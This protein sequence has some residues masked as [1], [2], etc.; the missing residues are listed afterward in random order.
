MAPAPRLYVFDIDGTLVTTKSGDTR[1]HGAADWKWLPGRLEMARS[2]YASGAHI[3]IATNQSSIA[4]AEITPQIQRVADAIGPAVFVQ[5]AY[6]RG[7][8]DPLRKPAPGMLIAAMRRFGVTPA[9]TVM[10][11]DRPEDH[12]AAMNAGCRFVAADAFFRGRAA[13]E[14]EVA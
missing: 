8:A 9:E 11:G 12:G 1:R 6:E 10:V 13:P 5:I 3:A 14:R 7:P 4:P 2:L